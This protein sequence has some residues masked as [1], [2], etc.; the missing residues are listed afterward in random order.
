MMDTS[1]LRA[2]L[3]DIAPW[4]AAALGLQIGLHL[5]WPAQLA[6]AML[7]RERS[8]QLRSVVPDERVLRAKA[9]SL[10]ADSVQLA[11]RLTLAKSRQIVGSDPAA[12]L[13][14]RIVPLLGAKGWKL[15]RVKA[16]ASGGFAT[17][18][19]GAMTS[20]A[21]ALGGVHEIRSL[22]LSVKIR[23]LSLRPNP[24]GRLTIDLQVAVPTRETP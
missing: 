8:Q 9:D 5:L 13:A 6:S 24:S 22:P 3:R 2:L 16:D 7:D 4:A 17:L 20:F 12:L 15:D 21:D 14:A 18:D 1:R 23:R 10:I 11:E 19:L